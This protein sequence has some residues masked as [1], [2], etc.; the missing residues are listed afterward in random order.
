MSSRSGIEAGRAF[1]RMFLHDAQLRTQIKGLQARM[2]AV[3]A[4]MN[5]IGSDALRMGTR[6]LLPF[7]AAL[8]VFIPFSDRMQEVQAVTGATAEEF[9][10]LNDQAKE[11]GRTTSFTASQ[12]AGA[13]AELGRAGFDPSQIEAATEHTLSLARASG[14]ELPRAAE[15]M[16]SSL[17]QFGKSA[18]DSQEV[19]DILTATVNNSAQGMEDLFEALKLVGPIA[20]E[21]GASLA[22]TATAAGILANN[23]LK[24]SI[25][26][27]ALARAYK[28]L[29]ASKTQRD[30]ERLGVAVSDAAGNMRPLPAIIAEIGK[31]T[32][33]MGNTERLSVFEDLFGRGQA[34]AL[35]L[36]SAS[37]EVFDELMEKIADSNGIAA[38]TAG[39][40]DTKLGGSL[41]RML[42]AIEGVGLA[43]GKAVEGPA[44]DLAKWVVDTSGKVSTFVERNHE[45]VSVI[46]TVGLVLTTLGGV[47]ISVGGILGVAAFA[48]TGYA[49]A[50]AA[51]ASAKAWL[52]ALS[53]PAGWVAIGIG[54][55]LAATAVY[56]ISEAYGEWANASEAARA[57]AE[58]AGVA[59]EDMA[60]AI[61]GI[62]G[63]PDVTVEGV[64]SIVKAD[65]ALER[66]AVT[67]A[68]VRGETQAALYRAAAGDSLKQLSLLGGD[69]EQGAADRVNQM[70]QSAIP[71]AEK[72]QRKLLELNA[73]YNELGESIDPYVRA[74]ME[75]ALIDDAT[76][77]ISKLQDLQDEI[78]V[79]SGAATKAEIEMRKMLD[80]GM[81]EELATYLQEQ[82]EIRDRL[83][84]QKEKE[85][86]LEKEL[87]R[88]EEQR[89]KNLRSQAEQI[90][91]ENRTSEERLQLKLDELEQLHNTIDPTTGLPFLSDADYQRELTDL[92]NKQTEEASQ[93]A[94][95]IQNPRRYD[96]DSHD[97][98]TVEG[99][100]KLVDLYNNRHDFEESQLEQLIEA[101]AKSDEIIQAIKKSGVIKVAR[102]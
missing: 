35:K 75:L 66:L 50:I 32:E 46:G 11:L 82:E 67:I 84:E 102:F 69:T 91:E 7:A 74:E 43:I 22:E 71:P 92:H 90:R 2:R 80:A 95:R 72:L 9:E 70:M 54:A 98:R 60:K 40:M 78:D 26:G 68:S 76:G 62:E 45:L 77:A 31:A 17:A 63:G 55:G 87:K 15:I 59:T 94:D 24:G 97:L 52:L 19:A 88:E 36:A 81:S 93:Q 18:S 23:G 65:T 14:T 57:K 12:V 37:G 61:D 48:M 16:A 13:M 41:R 1:V 25:A 53:G 56:G 86:E 38:E 30:L 3:G 29:S 44:E 101:N 83:L 34:A 89:L 99:A 39:I 73:A 33:G 5:R 10:R 100:S 6:I 28:N 51:A 42:S 64:D 47:L 27:T 4:T 49:A 58:E 96:P 8:A 79:L 85:I 20:Y 21:A